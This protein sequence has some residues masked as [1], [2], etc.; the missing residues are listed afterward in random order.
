MRHIITLTKLVWE[1][2]EDIF[3]ITPELYRKL[4]KTMEKEE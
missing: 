4:R 2:A 3:T 1:F